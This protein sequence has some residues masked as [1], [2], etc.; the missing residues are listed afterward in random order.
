VLAGRAARAESGRLPKQN[1]GQASTACPTLQA[2]SGE[3]WRRVEAQ[4]KACN[5]SQV[6]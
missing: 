3:P 4:S 1:S 6:W 2:V 5:D